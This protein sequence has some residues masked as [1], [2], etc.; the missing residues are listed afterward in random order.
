MVNWNIFFAAHSSRSSNMYYI[1]DEMDPSFEEWESEN[2]I[3]SPNTPPVRKQTAA[4]SSAA[5]AA[6]AALSSDA[7]NVSAARARTPSPNPQLPKQTPNKKNPEDDSLMPDSQNQQQQNVNQSQQQQNVNQ[8]QQQNVN[9]NQN[10]NQQNVN[11]TQ[12]QTPQQVNLNQ[13]QQV[14][15]LQ[16]LQSQVGDSKLEKSER[17][18]NEQLFSPIIHFFAKSTNYDCMPPSVKLIVFD[19]DMPVKEAFAI[20]TQND[21]SFATLWDSQSGAIV[22]MITISDL[23]EILLDFRDKTNVIKDLIAQHN[24]RKWRGALW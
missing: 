1:M 6:P 3:E 16:E 4:R 13:Q 19:V 17:Q 20:A 7:P 18:M 22:G 15:Q 10:M 12:T 5:A 2:V 23:I 21:L 14:N 11:Q 9:M 24:I 8:S